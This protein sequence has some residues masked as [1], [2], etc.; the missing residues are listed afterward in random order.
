MSEPVEPCPT[1]REGWKPLDQP[2][3]DACY[4]GK[5]SRLRDWIDPMA[6]VMRFLDS[7]EGHGYGGMAEFEIARVG[8]EQMIVALEEN[9][10]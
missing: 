8:V 10:S 3:C 5:L 1:C 2:H 4:E 9:C 6:Q 7:I